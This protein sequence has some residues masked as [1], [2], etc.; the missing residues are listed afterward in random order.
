MELFKI[1]A[2]QGLVQHDEIITSETARPKVGNRL[3]LKAIVVGTFVYNVE[4]RLGAGA[5]IARS[6]GNHTEVVA[7]DVNYILLKIPLTEIRKVISTAWASIGSVSNEEHRLVS[8]FW[9]TD[10]G[11]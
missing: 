1:L 3:P 8:T 4:L 2:L 6:A 10:Q 9:G 5:Q 11:G 7:Q